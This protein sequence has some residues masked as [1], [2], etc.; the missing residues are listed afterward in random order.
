MNGASMHVQFRRRPRRNRWHLPALRKPR[1]SNRILFFGQA[2]DS[3]VAD[4][5]RTKFPV[6]GLRRRGQLE[7]ENADAETLFPIVGATVTCSDHNALFRS[8]FPAQ[9]NHHMRDRRGPSV[10]VVAAPA[11]KI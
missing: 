4:K 7:I 2:R 6:V 1:T 5:D 10:V 9:I 3:S 8:F 11:K